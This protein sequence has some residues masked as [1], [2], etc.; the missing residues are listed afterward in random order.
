MVSV[1]SLFDSIKD[2]LSVIVMECIVV[3]GAA[4]G[5]VVV[6]TDGADSV[7]CDNNVIVV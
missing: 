5:G 6:D 3:V 4:C 7:I 1:I 2:A